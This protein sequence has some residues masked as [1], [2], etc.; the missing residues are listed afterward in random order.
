MGN[1]GKASAKKRPRGRP[2]LKPG[3]G[4]RSSFNTR[5]TSQLKERLERDAKSAGRSLSEQ[6]ERRLE[7]AYLRDEA[8]DRVREAVLKDIY[9]SFGGKRPFVDMRY[10]S[11][12]IGLIEGTRKK[13]WRD[14]LKTNTFVVDAATAFF[15]KYGPEGSDKWPGMFHLIDRRALAKDVLDL[16]EK[17]TAPKTGATPAPKKRRT[18]KG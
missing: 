13:F 12:L 10:L 18:K 8:D 1:A 6:I 7:E 2:P 3:R 15:E 5:I 9:D 11:G 16:Y 14:D 4:K 17:H